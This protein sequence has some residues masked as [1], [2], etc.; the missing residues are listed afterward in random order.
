M[1][2]LGN[3][4]CGICAGRFH[5]LS[6]VRLIEAK[7]RGP[8]RSES[9]R[10]FASGHGQPLSP[11]GGDHDFTRKALDLIAKRIEIR[12][13]LELPTALPARR[14]LEA[15]Q[16]PAGPRGETD[17]PTLSVGLRE[18]RHGPG[19]PTHRLQRPPPGSSVTVKLATKTSRP[20]RAKRAS[21]SV[22]C[23]L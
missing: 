19:G 14:S 4:H 6:P 10:S 12:R 15:S 9:E 17:P 16:E 18:K 21:S 8:R 22:F 2:Q 5:R 20:R 23:A 3:S 1:T 13:L 11:T 7:A